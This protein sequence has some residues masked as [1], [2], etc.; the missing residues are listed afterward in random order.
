MLMQLHDRDAEIFRLKRKVNALLDGI[1][2]HASKA[3]GKRIIAS[4]KAATGEDK[5]A[6][7]GESGDAV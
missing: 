6:G 4:M 5:R 3:A 1:R 7:N 2:E